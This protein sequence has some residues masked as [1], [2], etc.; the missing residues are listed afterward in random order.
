MIDPTAELRQRLAAAPATAPATFI[1]P[2]TWPDLK[3]AE[4]E[5]LQRL[6]AAATN[7][8]ATMIAVDNDGYPLWSNNEIALDKSAPVDSRA[9]DFMI[10]LHFESPRFLDIYSYYALWQPIEFYTVFGYE[11]SVEQM[12]THTDCLSCR[13]DDADAHARNLF[14]GARKNALDD[15]P[16]LFHSPPRPY[17]ETTI[18]SESRLF[19][20]G[21]NWERINNERGRH[22][23]LLLRLNDE[24]LID[25]Y[26]PK[27]FQGVEPWRGFKTYRGELP[28]DGN[29]VV[30][31]VNRA[32]ICLALSSAAHQSSALMSNRLFEG[33]AA[34]AAVIAN[35]NE[36]IDKYFSDVVYVIDDD[37]DEF[38]LY[39]QTRAIMDQI[40]ANPGDARVRAMEGQRRLDEAFSLERSISTIVSQHPARRAS[41]ERACLSNASVTVVLDYRGEA[42]WEVE[43]ALCDLAKQSR[44]D[45]RA[46]VICSDAM[47]ARHGEYIAALANGALKAVRTVPGSPV[48]SKL[49]H[50]ASAANSFLSGPSVAQILSDVDTDYVA[51]MSVDERWFA[52]HLGSLANA[53][54][55]EPDS[56]FAIAGSLEEK[57]VYQGARKRA[58]R[59]VDTVRFF[60]DPG[61]FA[62]DKLNRDRGRFLYRSSLLRTLPADCLTLLDGEE[63]TFARLSAAISGPLAQTGMAT[64]VRML[65]RRRALPSPN[66]PTSRQRG[67]IVDALA[68]NSEFAFNVGF[69]GLPGTPSIEITPPEDS[70]PTLAVNRTLVFDEDP[71]L[72]GFLIEGFSGLEKS[73]VW[74]DGTDAKIAFRAL[75]PGATETGEMDLVLELSGRPANMDGR[76][77]H[78]S[79]RVNDVQIAYIELNNFPDEFRL[80]LPKGLLSTGLCLLEL[81]ADH[82]DPVLGKD[83]KVSDPRYLSVM[84]HKLCLQAL[85]ATVFP[86][87]PCDEPKAMRHG[88]SGRS[89]VDSGFLAQEDDRIWLGSAAGKIRFTV[90]RTDRPRALLLRMWAHLNPNGASER[91]VA[92]YLNGTLA[93]TH[94]IDGAVRDYLVPLHRSLIE[95]D[96]HCLVSIK[97]DSAEVVL[98]LDGHVVDNRVLS[99]CLS[100]VGLIDPLEAGR[101]ERGWNAKKSR[102][103]AARLQR[104]LARNG[105]KL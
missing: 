49:H 14:I 33:L 20:V 16:V 41:F 2:H 36:F 39:T 35:P 56:D 11:K 78:C 51:F 98:G 25:I 63:A 5:V 64:Y 81:H 42:I 96:G 32:G 60:G 29:S 54:D 46:V 8:G 10:C 74:V 83:G 99:V 57:T 97:P 95:E 79:I 69:S 67:Y 18:C 71:S 6:S 17:L 102:S 84:L 66:I 103:F 76:K 59:S 1:V 62:N 21:I 30:E 3:N 93:A 23:E 24:D 77:Q 92:F 52:D 70:Y 44:V 58:K 31:A 61:T 88:G 4:Y 43:D 105:L 53:L 45:V 28:F 55:R 80:R 65:A 90:A 73:G 101:V 82:A 27:V 75:N 12:L 37:C 19:Y 68:R 50:A 104:F 89:L 87:L 22:H 9:I 94:K 100:L 72:R 7:V 15:F 26:G 86:D 40:R 38:E 91:S 48:R 47:A 34:G 13:S 85:S